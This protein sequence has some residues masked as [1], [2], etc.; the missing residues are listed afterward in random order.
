MS[1]QPIPFQRIV[2]VCTNVRTS[3]PRVSCGATGGA[4][5]RERLKA[6]V[7]QHGLAVAMGA[8]VGDVVAFVEAARSGSAPPPEPMALQVPPTFAGRPLVT[9][10]LV[11]FAHRHGVQIHVW[12]VNET[13][14]MRRLLELGVDGLMSDFPGRLRRVVDE[15]GHG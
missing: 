8:S 5:L 15:R 11:G 13:D 9:P 14:E 2:F 1:D 10:E 6:L 7:K 12:T 4:E 3:G